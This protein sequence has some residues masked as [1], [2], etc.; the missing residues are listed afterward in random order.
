MKT[1]DYT[2]KKIKSIST[3]ISRYYLIIKNAFWKNKHS[4]SRQTTLSYRHYI[5]PKR[6]S[7][8]VPQISLSGLWLKEAGFQIGDT[9]TIKIKKGCLVIRKNNN[10][11]SLT[12]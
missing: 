4:N 6:H 1:L 2:A 10:K 7:R 9:M 5:S 12:N 3:K 11:K 8:V